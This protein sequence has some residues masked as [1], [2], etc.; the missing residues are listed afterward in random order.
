MSGDIEE[1]GVA[2][3][4]EEAKEAMREMGMEL[5]GEE[6]SQAGVQWHKVKK[7]KKELTRAEK[8]KI[9][10]V[11]KIAERLK[12]LQPEERYE[13]RKGICGIIMLLSLVI[14]AVLV[15]KGTATTVIFAGDDEDMTFV[16][17]GA[18]FAAPCVFWFL[19]IYIAPCI[20]FGPCKR[21]R[22]TRATIHVQRAERKKP[23]MFNDMIGAA[24][25]NSKPPI[26]RTPLW[27][28]FRKKEY[29]IVCHTMEEFQEMF[30][31]RTG[32]PPSR[33]LIKLREPDGSSYVFDF[34]PEE[35]ILDL[36]PRG[37]KRNT[38]FWIYTKGGIE[39]DIRSDETVEVEVQT[40]GASREVKRIPRYRMDIAKKGGVKIP[41]LFKEGVDRYL[42]DNNTKDEIDEELDAMMASPPTTAPRTGTR[43]ATTNAASP[44]RE[45]F[46]SK[47]LSP[48]GDLPE[49]RVTKKKRGK[50]SVK[51][52]ISLYS[53]QKDGEEPDVDDQFEADIE[54]IKRERLARENAQRIDAILGEFEK[55]SVFHL[56]QLD[57]VDPVLDEKLFDRVHTYSSK[58]VQEFLTIFESHRKEERHVPYDFM[59]VMDQYEARHR[60]K[61]EPKTQTMKKK[62]R[63]SKSGGARGDVDDV[64]LF[65][66]NN[67]YDGLDS[68]GN[69]PPFSEFGPEDVVE[70]YDL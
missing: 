20:P 38:M 30:S 15:M 10:I 69:A 60:I 9:F 12:H 66:D 42:R 35:F 44:F 23:S 64:S 70:E 48:D 7:P 29:K 36:E 8:E 63:R 54:R 2:A 56:E 1:G 31:F 4:E 21:M 37:V 27:C 55:R 13:I 57:Y 62:K 14:G 5:P 65:T 28:T 45:L 41:Q 47:K 50:V 59:K 26:I 6:K 25:E 3:G 40:E 17:A 58:Q 61:R 22:E 67:S 33:Q 46:A 18:V 24:N 53:G 11:K 34:K 68:P 19:Y 51:K 52:A 16:I 32:V 43:G 39:N 49:F